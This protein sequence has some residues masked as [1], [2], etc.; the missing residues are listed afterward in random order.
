[1]QSKEFISNC[2]AL[3][4]VPAEELEFSSQERADT[5]ATQR[6]KKVIV[7]L[8]KVEDK[9]VFTRCKHGSRASLYPFVSGRSSNSISCFHMHKLP[10]MS[11]EETGLREMEM[12]QKWQERNSKLMDEANSS[13]PKGGTRSTPEED[14]VAEEVENAKVWDDWKDDHPRGAVH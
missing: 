14:E 11:I 8:L 7:P 12:M 3:E 9:H 4:L 2:E 6:A 13:R 10:T 1:M 5:Q